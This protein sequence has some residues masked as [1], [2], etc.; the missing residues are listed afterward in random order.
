MERQLLSVT[1]VTLLI[2]CYQIQEAALQLQLC[3]G[4]PQIATTARLIA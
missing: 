2:R 3:Q 4:L 1:V